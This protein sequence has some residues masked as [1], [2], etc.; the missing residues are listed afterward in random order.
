MEYDEFVERSKKVIVAYQNSELI[1]S[2]EIDSKDRL[3]AQGY[4]RDLKR[5]NHGISYVDLNREIVSLGN[6]GFNLDES[7]KVLE[8]H[9]N[10]IYKSLLLEFIENFLAYLKTIFGGNNQAN[11]ARALDLCNK[12]YGVIGVNAGV[13]IIY[14]WQLRNA[15]A[16]NDPKQVTFDECI[17]KLEGNSEAIKIKEYLENHG[18][19]DWNKIDWYC[20]NT[21]HEIFLVE[22]NLQAGGK[23]LT[24]THSFNILFGCA[25]LI[26]QDKA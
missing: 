17:N 15:I 13:F 12:P 26:N 16:H 3:I 9:Q 21:D 11:I 2:R 22:K 25:K 18:R 6:V 19:E 1:F 23:M 4:N 7:K 8:A 10:L 14:L 20:T 5:F 24:I